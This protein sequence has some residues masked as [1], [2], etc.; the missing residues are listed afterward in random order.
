MKASEVFEGAIDII[1]AY[2]WRRDDYGSEQYPHCIVG[3]IHE[4]GA[5]HPERFLTIALRKALTPHLVYA[6]GT[7]RRIYLGGAIA[8]NDDYAQEQSEVVATL[9]TAYNRAIREEKK[10]GLV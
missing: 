7:S 6:M 3:A 1:Q 8:W 9:L 4:S 2:G 5:G 10:N